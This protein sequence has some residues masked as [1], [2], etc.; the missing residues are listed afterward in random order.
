MDF[1]FYY[2]FFLFAP[3]FILTQD[4]NLSFLFLYSCEMLT[5]LF[6]V[7]LFR[8]LQEHETRLQAQKSIYGSGSESHDQKWWTWTKC[9]PFFYLN[10]TLFLL[11]HMPTTERASLFSFSGEK[12][13]LDRV[14]LQKSK[15]KFFGTAIECWEL[16][17]LALQHIG[18][19]SEITDT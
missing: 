5:F 16:L 7:L 13:C 2:L 15:D 11:F 17:L 18:V 1:S 6:D 3:N 14:S 10:S 4:I 9:N 19:I 8:S 12:L